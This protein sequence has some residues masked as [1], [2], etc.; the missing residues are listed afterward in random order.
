MLDGQRRQVG[1]S[2]EVARGSERLQQPKKDL[3]VTRSRVENADVWLRQ[4]GAHVPARH[5]NRHRIAQDLTVGRET[6]E[7]QQSHPGEAHGLAAVEQPFSPGP[8][9]R[10]DG[11]VGVIGVQEQVDVGQRHRRSDR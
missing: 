11:G 10:M 9:G 8:R 2:R 6:N 1:I 3:G 4:P 7:A 5:G